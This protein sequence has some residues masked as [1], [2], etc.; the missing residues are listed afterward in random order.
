MWKKSNRRTAIGALLS[1][2]AFPLL[3]ESQGRPFEKRKLVVAS[4]AG[5]APDIVARQIA[6]E[7]AERFG[8]DSHVENLPGAA[9]MLAVNRV[10]SAPADGATLLLANSGL[11]NT[12]PQMLGNESKF[13]PEADLAPLAILCKSPFFLVTSA[14]SQVS[15]IADIR[16]RLSQADEKTHFGIGTLYGAHHVAGSLLFKRLGIKAEAVS[17]KQTSQLVLDVA[18]QRV[19]F[20]I[21]SWNN[22]QPMLLSKKLRAIA[23]L[24][25]KRLTFAAN[26]PA[27]AEQG[28]ADCAHEGWIGLFHRREVHPET[29]RPC[30]HALDEL[31]RGPNP[32]IDMAHLGYSNFYVNAE[33]SPAFV[34]KDIIRNRQLLKQ[35]TLN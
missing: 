29:V 27:L 9:G 15:S 24:T 11:I 5:G 32:L 1:A 16:T 4:S 8:I 28:L 13:D 19:P 31:F 20:G 21:T 25:A 2:T 14:N 26:V 35:I 34:N 3:A 10:L 7:W 18:S 30:A 33:S 17:Y 23:V 6:Q 22:V 12:V